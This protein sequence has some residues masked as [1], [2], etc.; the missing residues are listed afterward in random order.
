MRKSACWEA[1]SAGKS[2][3]RS[4]AEASTAKGKVLKPCQ[5]ASREKKP[6]P[7]GGRRY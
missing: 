2:D 6:P 1:T 4:P 3:G 5:L 7:Q